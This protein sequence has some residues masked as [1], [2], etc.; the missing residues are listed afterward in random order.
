MQLRDGEELAARLGDNAPVLSASN[1]HPWVWE[2]ARSLW[3]S[4]HYRE[5]VRAAS[6]KVNAETQNKLRRRD[7]SETKLF[8]QALSNEPP[9]GTTYRLRPAGDDGGA[10][11]LSLRRGVMAFAEG[12]YAGIRNPASHDEGDLD[13]QAALEQ[14]AAF[15]LLAR[16]VDGAAVITP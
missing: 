6:V 10:T 16:W 3:Q 14:L 7:I 13:E 1:L 5:A 11:A 4:G 12:C 8:Q 15:S 9:A 2:G